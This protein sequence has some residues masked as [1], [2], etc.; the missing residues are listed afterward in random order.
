MFKEFIRKQQIKQASRLTEI[1][2]DLATSFEYLNTAIN[3]KNDDNVK[4][5]AKRC[6][7]KVHK[8]HTC[9]SIIEVIGFCQLPPTLVGGLQKRASVTSKP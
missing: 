1:T 7:K 3:N 9:L 6:R 8:L 5:W 4:K 2:Q